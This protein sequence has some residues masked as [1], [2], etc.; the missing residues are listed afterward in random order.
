[1]QDGGLAQT[2]Q[3]LVH[4]LH[5]RCRT[6]LLTGRGQVGVESEV[7]RMGAVDKELGVVA[8]AEFGERPMSPVVP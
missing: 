8:T 2:G 6:R 3:D 4:R 5:R 7:W 1:M